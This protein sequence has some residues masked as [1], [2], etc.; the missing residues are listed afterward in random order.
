M[1]TMTS[2]FKD[3]ENAIEYSEESSE[4]GRPNKS[5]AKRDS[6]HLVAVGEDIVKLSS[7]EI[8]TLDLPDQLEEAVLTAKKI[9][10]RSG[11]KRQRLYI[12][13]LLRSIDSEH[14]EIQLK[15]IQHRHDT[16][17]A[18]FKRL[19]VWRDKLIEND[20]SVLNEI[21]SNYPELDRQHINQLIRAAQQE[22]KLEKTPTAARKLF[23][24]LNELSETNN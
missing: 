7:E 17:T 9:K 4:H 3:N 20:K 11:L 6:Q 21:I 15:K 14:I 23:K 13:K 18:L 19:E 5:Q 8:K 24:Y 22:K 16:N 1:T 10:S 12:G 2:N